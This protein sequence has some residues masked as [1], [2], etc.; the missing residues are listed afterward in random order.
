MTSASITILN[1]NT[2]VIF[3]HHLTTYTVRY[4]IVRSCMI[5]AM[6]DCLTHLVIIQRDWLEYLS[7]CNTSGWHITNLHKIFL[8]VDLL[9]YLWYVL[10]L[11]YLLIFYLLLP[12][13]RCDLWPRFYLWPNSWPWI[14]FRPL[15]Y[16]QPLTYVLTCGL[17]F[18]RDPL[19]DPRPT[20]LPV[21]HVLTCDPVFLFLTWDQVFD[22]RLIFWPVNS[23]F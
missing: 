23:F 19:I 9:F 3:Y 12:L 8:S 7:D 4:W 13:T 1:N 11:A 18:T 10:S 6:A 5:G 2:T 17:L 14:F 15:T 22:L 20:F 21:T 16:F